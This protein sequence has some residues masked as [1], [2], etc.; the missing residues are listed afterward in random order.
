MPSLQQT[1][2]NA[3]RSIHDRI[4]KNPLMYSLTN[5]ESLEEPYQWLLRKL[6]RFTSGAEA[7]MT[8]LFDE[9]SGF[10]IARRCRAHLLQEDLINMHIPFDTFETANFETIDTTLKAIGLLYVLEGSRK[11]G[12]FLSALLETRAPHLPMRYLKG[13]DLST[14]SEWNSFL[15]LL[16]R[17]NQEPI[18]EEV[19]AGAIR[20]FEILEDIFNDTK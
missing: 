6:Y 7:K 9:S 19:I 3:T 1:L 18:R 4:E 2:F 11:G 13:Y 14:D 12:A 16:E 17:Y 10:E 15:E 8:L 5:H 20:T